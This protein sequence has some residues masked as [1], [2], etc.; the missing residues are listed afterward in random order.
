MI[1]AFEC[2][3]F[4]AAF[5]FTLFWNSFIPTE[6]RHLGVGWCRKRTF[7]S[8]V[9]PLNFPVLSYIL[10]WLRHFSLALI[11]S[12]H[13]SIGEQVVKSLVLP[14]LHPSDSMPCPF[15]FLLI[16]SPL[17]YDRTQ[18][19]S[20]QVLIRI[21]PDTLLCLA[22]SFFPIPSWLPSLPLS[23]LISAL[24]SVLCGSSSMSEQKHTPIPISLALCRIHNVRRPANDIR[25]LV[26]LS[27][28]VHVM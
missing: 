9:S 3:R 5:T 1:I 2:C 12:P 20:F 15:L 27:L 16:T 10:W 21:S 8:N 13:C 18:E 23:L 28:R 17:I 26:F 4:H 22:P 6:K 24:W 7:E 14:F 25:S 19:N 11:P